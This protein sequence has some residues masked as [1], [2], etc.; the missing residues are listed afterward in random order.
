MAT[1]AVRVRCRTAEVASAAASPAADVSVPAAPG[2]GPAAVAAAAAAAVRAAGGEAAALA[3]APGSRVTAFHRPGAAFP[4][5][6]AASGRAA[7]VTGGGAEVTGAAASPALIVC[8]TAADAVVQC[9]APV[10]VSAAAEPPAKLEVGSSWFARAG[11]GTYHF[12][13]DHGWGDEAVKDMGQVTNVEVP[14]NP[15]TEGFASFLRVVFD[16]G[17]GWFV[18]P[19]HR[20]AILDFCA[21]T[22]VA[23]T[24]RT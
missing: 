17:G 7:A 6:P 13:A 23:I 16:S 20:T 22:G 11:D 4:W 10:T 12:F 19:V 9:A 21:T 5:L 3:A 1:V 14:P 8:V 24:D 15:D 18:A 2:D